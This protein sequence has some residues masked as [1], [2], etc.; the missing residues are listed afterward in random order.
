MEAVGIE[1]EYEWRMGLR[2]NWPT[3]GLLATGGEGYSTNRG[4]FAA[5]SLQI[6]QS[7]FLMK[8]KVGARSKIKPKCIVGR[9]GSGLAGEIYAAVTRF[10]RRIGQ[11]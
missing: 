5:D 10:Y 1:G 2:E 11:K 6:K 9:R 7:G 4:N 8:S 3:R